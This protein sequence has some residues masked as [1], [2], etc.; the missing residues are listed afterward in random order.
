[1]KPN[2]QAISE[3][4]CLIYLVKTVSSSTI[5]AKSSMAE[6]LKLVPFRS[7]IDRQNNQARYQFPNQDSFI[8]S[9]ILKLVKI[10]HALSSCSNV[11]WFAQVRKYRDAL[12]LTT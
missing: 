2:L 12:I 9:I 10:M 5:V 3:G 4:G 6:E 7:D 8:F 1:L 11:A